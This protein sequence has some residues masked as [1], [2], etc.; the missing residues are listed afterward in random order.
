MCRS[1]KC[2]DK[3]DLRC[4]S[5]TD[6]AR[7]LLA[8]AVQRLSRWERAVAAAEADGDASKI[9][10]A[11]S[12]V[13]EAINDIGVRSEVPEIPVEPPAPAPL[14]AYELAHT[15]DEDLERLWREHSSDLVGQHLVEREWSRREMQSRTD[16]DRDLF[17]ITS[18]SVL[19]DKLHSPEELTDGELKEVWLDAHVDP[20]LRDLAETEM[21]RRLLNHTDSPLED[22]ELEDAI[23]RRMEWSFQN[24]SPRDFR[25]YEATIITD[26]AH[27][28]AAGVRATPT[29]KQMQDE[30]DEY[31]YERYM[32]AEVATRGHL[33]NARG[34]ALKVDAW[35]LLSGNAK[36]VNAY[37]SEELLGFLSSTGGHMSFARFKA[38]RT[39]GD[40]EEAHIERFD[41][42]VSV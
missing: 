24:M 29:A 10:R 23:D 38:I 8:S 32:A 35:S 7:K 1:R 17:P 11:M 25:R 31:T 3:C 30:Y 5:H 15:D 14:D 28:T 12:R 18:F 36:R 4:P 13:I 2:G 6:P 34:R 19:V 33:L 22:P 16:F 26:P 21:D 9:D 20:Q 27:R 39:S 41:N 42:A 37:G 40:Y